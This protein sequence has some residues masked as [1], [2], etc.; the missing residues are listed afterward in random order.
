MSRILVTGGAGYIGAVTA[1]VL[2]RRGYGVVIVDDLSRGHEHNVKGLEF[3]K[4]SL[5]DT[6][7]LTELFKREPFDAVV[8]FA[9]HSMV[10]EST[11][12]PERYFLNNDG[13]SASLFSAMIEAGVKRLVFSSSAAVYGNPKKVPIPED[14]AFDPVN[15]YGA[16]KALV[17]Q[18]LRWLDQCSEFRS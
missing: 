10:G 12:M 13:G 7:A 3:H 17:E 5:L 6:R 1:H 14:H 8:H 9:A 15:P 18:M 11:R 4:L 2:A 16:S